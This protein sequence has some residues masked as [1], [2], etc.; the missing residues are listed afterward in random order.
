MSV[1]VKVG[2]NVLVGKGVDVACDVACIVGTCVLSGCDGLADVAK[3]V[4]S[5]L[6]SLG[7]VFAAL[8]NE[9]GRTM[10]ASTSSMA[11]PLF[12]K[13]ILIYRARCAANW[14]VTVSAPEIVPWK[15]FCFE[16]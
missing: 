11:V 15:P 4:V 5:A 10:K 16:S 14:A 6:S 1:A 12:W 7:F 13:V 3:T 8:S 9:G 2:T